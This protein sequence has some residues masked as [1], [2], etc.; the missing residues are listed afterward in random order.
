MTLRVI[1]NLGNKGIDQQK[2]IRDLLCD[3]S[4]EHDLSIL[5]LS[6][7]LDIDRK[8]VKGIMDG[9]ITDYKINHV[10]KIM[11]L[12]D[13]DSK[14][15][16]QLYTSNMSQEEVEQVEKTKKIAFLLNNF[17]LEGLKKCN[18]ISSTTQ[19]EDIEKRLCEFL[20]LRS[21][22]DYRGVKSLSPLYSKSN[23]GKNASKQEK[24]LNFWLTCAQATFSKINNPY[25]YNREFL[26]EFLKQIKKYTT[27]PQNGF[28]LV[29]CV[30]YR[31]GITVLVQSYLTQ[32]TAYGVSMLVNNKPCV[33]ITDLGKRYDKLWHTLLHELYHIINDYEYIE[34]INIHI[35]DSETK[36]IFVS[37]TDAD[38][39][40]SDV[41]L[42]PKTFAIVEKIIQIP[43]KVD[44]VAQKQGI[45]NSII[46]GQY[47]DRLS[48]NKQK[49]SFP[50][51]SKY[52]LKSNI[53]LKNII[54]KPEDFRS[55]QEATATLQEFYNRKIS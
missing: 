18:I 24:M 54:Y 53:A 32:T 43:Y 29:L 5:A 23:Y 3:Y 16:M 31:L 10:L 34:K 1:R 40:A 47:L 42:G 2:S 46:Y 52:L 6:K 21:I 19:Y 41:L 48:P 17:D 30:L 55:L 22:F 9:S 14:D 27:D 28:S 7:I 12:F 49:E 35:S 8:T 45:H 36:D 26:V 11:N 39:F 20:D 50:I 51:Y 38:Q 37:E 33:I 4:T 13:L 44:I 25:Q 15:F